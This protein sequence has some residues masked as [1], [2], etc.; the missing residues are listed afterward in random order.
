MMNMTAINETAD[1]I[2]RAYAL[3]PNSTAATIADAV[4]TYCDDPDI[5]RADMHRIAV[6]IDL[7]FNR[8]AAP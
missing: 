1:M 6:R 4:R 5:T 3:T 8:I 7:N 2:T